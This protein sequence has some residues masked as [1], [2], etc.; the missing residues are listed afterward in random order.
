MVQLVGR[1]SAGLLIKKRILGLGSLNLSDRSA[2]FA[3]ASLSFECN[4]AAVTGLRLGGSNFFEH[5]VSMRSVNWSPDRYVFFLIL[6]C[7]CRCAPSNAIKVTRREIKSDAD[8]VSSHHRT[9]KRSRR[10]LSE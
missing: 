7:P 8:P 3:S 6:L 9:R 10:G 4:E 1:L 2:H 5:S